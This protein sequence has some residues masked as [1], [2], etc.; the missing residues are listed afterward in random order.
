MRELTLNE[1][2]LRLLKKGRRLVLKG[3]TQGITERRVN[4]K[5]C[6]CTWGA[7]LKADKS[8][9]KAVS[10]AALDELARDHHISNAP[11]F[12]SVIQFNDYKRRSQSQIVALFD[13][14]ILRVERQL[15]G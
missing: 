4:G 2:L 6:Y 9:G 3:W 14:T 15:N 11:F 7:I 10:T 1:K 8:V 12:G 5:Q 13:R